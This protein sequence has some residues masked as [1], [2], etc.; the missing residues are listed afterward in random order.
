MSSSSQARMMSILKLAKAGNQESL[1]E[2]LT[3]YRGYLLGIATVRLDSRLRNRCNPSD[4]V[5]ETML[6]AF[7]DFHQFR[8]ESEPEF[9]AWI[10]QILA[11]NLARL[12]EMHVLTGKRDARREISLDN[13]HSGSQSK[14]ENR[15]HWLA[16]D[17]KSPSSQFQQQEQLIQVVECLSH[18][19]GHYRDVLMLRHI[20]GLSFEEV[21]GRLG[22]SSG[23]VRMI[24]LRALEQLREVLPN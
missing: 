3:L 23:A 13:R 4:V 14:L 19:P 18:L 21:G 8:G 10:R 6:E 1:G 12:I 5:Q 9:L 11:H 2:L 17:Q 16:D 24:W 20:E 22:K 15:N 7:R